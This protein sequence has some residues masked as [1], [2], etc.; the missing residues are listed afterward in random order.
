MGNF[1]LQDSGRELPAG[2]KD[3]LQ[4][5]CQLGQAEYKMAHSLMFQESC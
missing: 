3:I 4:D 2:E 1:D 5:G